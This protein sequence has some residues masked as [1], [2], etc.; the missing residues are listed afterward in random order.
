MD[1]FRVEADIFIFDIVP[2]VVHINTKRR[3]QYMNKDYIF[4]SRRIGTT[5]YKV[6]VYFNNN[7]TETMEDKIFRVILNHP[8]ANDENCGIMTSTPQMSRSA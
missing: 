5:T 3:T 7:S 4:M 2:F 6:K 1:V 8:L